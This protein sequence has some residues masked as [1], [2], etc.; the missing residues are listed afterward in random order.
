[1]ESFILLRN[2]YRKVSAE[3]LFKNLKTLFF[4]LGLDYQEKSIKVENK[5]SPFFDNSYY[6]EL[7]KAFLSI[8]EEGNKPV[9]CDSQSILAYKNLFLKLQNDGEFR[10]A[11][12]KALKKEI[13]I[14]ECE[15]KFVFLPEIVL[16]ALGKTNKIARK[17]EG[18][19][20]AFVVDRELEQLAKD[21]HLSDRFS[22]LTGLKVRLF[23]KESYDYLLTCDKD[24]AFKMA[25]NDYYEMVDSGVDFIT[26]PN[27][28]E[29]YLLD[30]F[31][32]AIKKSAGR[33]DAGI[34]V[35]L[36]P[37]V[38]LATFVGMDAKKLAF[39]KHNITPKM[40]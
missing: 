37:Q 21:L 6:L 16:E 29:F 35:L 22:V 19:T 31:H 30:S 36:I 1:M 20:C 13:D 39:D 15:Q 5:F 9:F 33:D 7:L 34:P 25:S 2:D 40:L 38:I 3:I 11:I 32:K 18:F 10:E 4:E 14:L 24:L 23:F 12:F 28:G 26:T 27:L 17:W 8:V